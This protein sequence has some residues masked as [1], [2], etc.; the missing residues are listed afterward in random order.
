MIALSNSYKILI[1]FSLLIFLSQEI[2]MTSKSLKASGENNA[3]PTVKR[4]FDLYPET[5]EMHTI[6]DC[7]HVATEPGDY[8][9]K[10]SLSSA[11]R[12]S[13]DKLNENEF[14]EE[15][16]E[17]KE[18]EDAINVCGL[19]IIGEPNTLVEI[20]MKHYD[21]N[22]NSGGLMAFVDGWELNG[23]YFPAIND[24]HRTLEDRL[25]EFCNNYKRWP[26]VMNKKFFRSSQNAALLQYRLPT[27]GSFIANVR[28]HKITQPCNILVHDISALYN[29]ANYGFKRNCSISA[30]F[31]AVVQLTNMK[32]GGKSVRKGKVS[33]ECMQ[34][35]D[36]LEIGGSPGL[37]STHMEKSSDICGYAET[38]GP[39]Q[40]IFCGV[41]TAR[42]VSSGRY[43][44]HVSIMIRKADAEDLDL[45]TLVCAF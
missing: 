17:L 10:K 33:Y 38:P 21:V 16:L 34:N 14:N 35:D 26:H 18:L 19:Y 11:Q 43:Q 39:E 5:H 15:G 13:F 45:A 8:V 27:K 29:L 44:N 22:C 36:Y 2:Q 42:L 3:W 40:A 20:T 23:E 12:F 9:F 31:P 32:V 25:V 1:I 37:D 4:A 7:M 28:F 6:T 41:T 30:L 24:H